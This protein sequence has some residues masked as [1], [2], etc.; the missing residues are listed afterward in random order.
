[1]F[2]DSFPAH[3]SFLTSFRV[4]FPLPL[5][6]PLSHR[7]SKFI[8]VS[9]R[10]LH[11][12]ESSRS[13]DWALDNSVL[14]GGCF[15]A[16][17]VFM[18]NSSLP[19]FNSIILTGLHSASPLFVKY[20]IRSVTLSQLEALSAFCFFP[21]KRSSQQDASPPPFVNPISLFF[22][23]FRLENSRPRKGLPLP[24]ARHDVQPFFPHERVHGFSF[25]F[26]MF[27]NFFLSFPCP[28]LVRNL[29]V[30]LPPFPGR[31]WGGGR[32]WR[33]LPISQVLFFIFRGFFGPGTLAAKLRA[34]AGLSSPKLLKQTRSFIMDFYYFFFRVPFSLLEV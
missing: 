26:P 8:I 33:L 22:L 6:A 16:F 14:V 29:T 23:H 19:D 7:K 11:L 21:R 4:H 30:C 13:R 24:F 27:L 10:A 32:T 34:F 3:P 5:E 31:S 2:L 17:L 20:D 1:L 25:F 28:P 15:S 9:F 18:K 12:D